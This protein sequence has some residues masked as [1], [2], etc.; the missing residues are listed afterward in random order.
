MTEFL[1]DHDIDGLRPNRDLQELVK[2]L[3]LMCG[4]DPLDIDDDA[5]EGRGSSGNE[6]VRDESD[7]SRARRT[8]LKFLANRLRR[9]LSEPLD[10]KT[11]IALEQLNEMLLLVEESRVSKA[12][13]DFFVMGM[14]RSDPTKTSAATLGQIKEAVKRF[15]GYAMLAYG[16][17]RFAFQRLSSMADPI[18]ICD[19]LEPWAQ[20]ESEQRAKLGTR[21]RSIAL[22]KS[23]LSKIPAN[24][25]WHLGFLTELGL[26]N[27]VAFAEVLKAFGTGER[28]GVLKARLREADRAEVESLVDKYWPPDKEQVELWRSRIKSISNAG[29]K[30][31]D[32]LKRNQELG[33]Q[34]SLRYLT[35]D[36]M[37]V[38][39]ATSMRH[40]W[41]FQET[42]EF[43]EE[44]F[45]R[46]ELKG[47]NLRWFD[48]TQSYEPSVTDKG[49]IEA[50][51]LKRARC[52]LY[53]AQESDTF[54]KDSELAATLAQG[55]PVIVYI[56]SAEGSDR[57]DAFAREL[58]TRPIAF[59]RK[60]LHTHFAEDF[61]QDVDRLRL[62]RQNL[63]EM[64]L[65]QMSDR[66]VTAKA[67]ELISLLEQ[68][69]G[70]RTFQFI[71]REDDD[72]RKRL[73]E[74]MPIA[75]QLMA[76]LEAVSMDKRA[77][78]IK[79]FHPLSMQVHLDTG[80]ANGVFVARSPKECAQLL[81][82][83][84]TDRLQFHIEPLYTG[85]RGKRLGTWLR[86]DKTNSR[87]RIVTYNQA[88]TN[89]FWNFYL[90]KNQDA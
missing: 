73:I 1:S 67:S 15:R 43:A 47:L 3:L 39:V 49:L 2:L 74:K 89:S 53:M 90:S 16:N 17:F 50:L 22:I 87:S 5:N 10:D 54:G 75:P 27:D 81:S 35:W 7:A 41:E 18:E 42:Y 64:G 34:N 71:G 40:P 46:P 88:V 69:E 25:T 32:I 13:F 51:M 72:L 76:A 58:G 36:Y 21:P 12:F 48:P 56:R 37:D 30:Q 24:E 68:L 33:R 9:V 59:Y 86:E 29:W 78:T 62:V 19:A 63:L 79:E 70:E 77:V 45:R 55:K 85:G 44:V 4:R 38:Y 65:G 82:G 20:S 14:R 83:L 26:R 11:K 57:L 80:V 66:I 31:Y 84:M 23:G 60:R 52:T 28:K 61:F 6:R 8:R